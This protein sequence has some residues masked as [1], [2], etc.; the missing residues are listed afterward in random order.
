MQMI[1]LP[2]LA[3]EHRNTHSL[4]LML[5]YLAPA[6]IFLVC[7]AHL[8]Q[9]HHIRPNPATAVHS[10]SLSELQDYREACNAFGLE[11]DAWQVAAD[12]QGGTLS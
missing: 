8:L 2:M 3:H 4:A 1:H 5:A 11:V 10:D 9:S 7:L 6:I 12:A